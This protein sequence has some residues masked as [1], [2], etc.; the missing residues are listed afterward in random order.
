MVV[1]A[2]NGLDRV[3]PGLIRPRLP[4][5]HVLGHRPRNVAPSRGRPSRAIAENSPED[6]RGARPFCRHSCVGHADAGL[7]LRPDR[8]VRVEVI[9][10]MP[11]FNYLPTGTSGK[12]HCTSCCTRE[13][14]APCRPGRLCAKPGPPSGRARLS[15]T[16]REG[17]RGGPPPTRGSRRSPA[18]AEAGNLRRHP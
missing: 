17:T 1:G 3:G 9:A 15:A 10:Q 11:L 6:G 12:E 4:A 7:M 13:D 2:Y 14:D 16:I 5:D 18:S 8:E